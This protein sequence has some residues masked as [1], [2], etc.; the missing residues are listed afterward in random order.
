VFGLDQLLADPQVEALLRVIIAGL[1]SALIGVE[2]E[3]EGKSAGL[4][5][6][7]LVGMGAAG[8][9]AVGT[10]LFGAGDAGSRIGQGIITGIGFLGAGVILHMERRVYG[11]TTAAGIWVAAVVGMAIGGGLYIVGAGVAVAVFVV[12]QL[13]GVERA[14][15][16]RR[17]RRQGEQGGSD[18]WRDPEV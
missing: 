7:V 9:T 15:H 4:R 1:L 10:I 18:E 11:L 17:S 2:R 14:L 3:L 12:L 6:Y 8:F 13:D 5:T 16:E